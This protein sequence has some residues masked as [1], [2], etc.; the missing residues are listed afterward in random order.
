VSSWEH[1]QYSFNLVRT[2]FTD[3]LGLVIYSKRVSTDAELAMIEAARVEMQ[4][5]PAKEAERQKKQTDDRELARQ[6]N[7]RSFRP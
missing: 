1:S 7:Q 4:E 6:K 5:A 3:H 2:S